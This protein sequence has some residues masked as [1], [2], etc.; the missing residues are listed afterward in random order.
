MGTATLPPGAAVETHLHEIDEEVLYVIE[1]TLTV[2]LAGEE[3]TVEPGG[4]VFVPPGT[5]IA[6]AN[7]SDSPTKVLGV[8]PRGELEECFRALYHIETGGAAGGW[9]PGMTPRDL[10]RTRLAHDEK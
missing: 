5:W 10:C 9:Q 6:L 4:I 7:R 1:G 3:H 2:T 8:L